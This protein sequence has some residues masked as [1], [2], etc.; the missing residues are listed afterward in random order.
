MSDS[1]D[2]FDSVINIYEEV[3]KPT[4]SDKD[5]DKEIEKDNLLKLEQERIENEKREEELKERE[6]K[7]IKTQ[8]KELKRKKEAQKILNKIKLDEDYDEYGDYY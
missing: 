8:K 1:E 4:A 2:L 3:K 7:R 6:K 5:K